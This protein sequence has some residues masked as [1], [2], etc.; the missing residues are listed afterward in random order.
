MESFNNDFSGTFSD[1]KNFQNNALDVMITFLKNTELSNLNKND[2]EYFSDLAS[3]V[4]NTNRFKITETQ[5]KLQDSV[6]EDLIDITIKL[7][8][9][10]K[11]LQDIKIQDMKIDDIDFNKIKSFTG[12]KEYQFTTDED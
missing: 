7:R 11:I 5:G 2:I 1:N 6:L 4:I 9:A 8:E 3:Y 12:N 10:D